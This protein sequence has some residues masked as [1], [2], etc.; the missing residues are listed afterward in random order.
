MSYTQLYLTVFNS[1]QTEFLLVDF[2]LDLNSFP[3]IRRQLWLVTIA[4]G[5]QVETG[6]DKSATRTLVHK[7]P[8]PVI[9]VTSATCASPRTTPQCSGSAPTCSTVVSVSSW[10]LSSSDRWLMMSH[11][12]LYTTATAF[13]L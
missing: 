2:V 7:S 11:S 8:R 10:I 5:V 1:T 4:N 9:S 12:L 13:C 6:A 3:L